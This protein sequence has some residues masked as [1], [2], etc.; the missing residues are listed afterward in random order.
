MTWLRANSSSWLCKYQN[1][2]L[3]LSSDMFTFN[4]TTICCSQG[5]NFTLFPLNLSESE[6]HCFKCW[7]TLIAAMS[8]FKIRLF[9]QLTDFWEED[10][11]AT[12]DVETAV[13]T[14]VVNMRLF[15]F[16]TVEIR[17]LHGGFSVL[18]WSSIKTCCVTWRCL[19]S[20]HKSQAVDADSAF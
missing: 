7:F 8:C 1:C 2:T 19:V 18:F 3:T 6:R 9:V 15:W 16:I 10:D 17:R 5:L 4:L 14:D 11:V 13:S 20:S 12:A